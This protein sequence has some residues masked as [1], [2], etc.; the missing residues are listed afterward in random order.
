M[1]D[2]RQLRFWKRSHQLVLDIYHA[3][4]R[5]PFHESFGLTRQ[6]RRSAFSVPANIAEACGR[7][8]QTGDPEFRRFLRIAMGSASELEYELLLARD[9]DYVSKLDHARLEQQITEI[10]RMLATYLLRLKN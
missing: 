10:K 9:L 2:F 5:F 8:R 6:L 1:K 7:S 3:T 4:R